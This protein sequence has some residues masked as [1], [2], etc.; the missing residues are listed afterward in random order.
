MTTTTSSS[1]VATTS[2]PASLEVQMDLSVARTYAQTSEHRPKNTDRAYKRRQEEFK[3]WCEEKGYPVETRTTVTGPKLHLFLEERVLNQPWKKQK[4]GAEQRHV[5]IA[6]LG[7]YIAAI[8]DLYQKQV[9]LKVNSN[10]HP[11]TDAIKELLRNAHYDEGQKKRK[12]Y[13]DR[14]IGTHLDG[15]S[16]VE[17]VYT[18]HLKRLLITCKASICS[19]YYITSIFCNIMFSHAHMSG[20]S[21]EEDNRVSLG[22]G[23]RPPSERCGGI[24][25]VSFR[26]VTG[27]VCPGDGT[28]RPSPNRTSG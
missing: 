8:T 15:Y 12:E 5:G 14:G 20:L 28:P 11:R 25:H 1:T 21:A 23:F 7:A 24:S 9:A 16:S 6:T 18:Y 13:V 26:P 3:K 19:L 10:G 22:D 4:A 2:T 17:Q 27:G